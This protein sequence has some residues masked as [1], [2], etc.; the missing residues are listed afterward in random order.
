MRYI[1]IIALLVFGG[2]LTVNELK[3]CPPTFKEYKVM[4]SQNSW[5]RGC[6]YYIGNGQL[7][8]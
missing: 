6:C 1:L 5:M 7:A 8:K 4:D 2:C 3:E